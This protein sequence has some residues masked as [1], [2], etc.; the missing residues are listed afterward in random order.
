[1]TL[2]RRKDGTYEADVR[3][4]AAGRLHVSLRTAS[5]R[6]A[7]VAHDA[8]QAL[9]R[10]GPAS[11]VAAL[12]ARTV[13]LAAV[14]ECYAAGQPFASLAPSAETVAPWPTLADACADYLAALHENERVSDETTRHA[15]YALATITEQFGAET[16]VDA[17]GYREAEAWARQR[18]RGGTVSPMHAA[19]AVV[20]FRA[21]YAWLAARE[22]KAARRE[23][24]P[25]RPL[26]CPIDAD[27]LPMKPPA[28]TAFLTK[29]EIARLLDATPPSLLAMVGLALFAGLRAGEIQA[30]RLEDV[31]GD[32]VKIASKPH[33]VPGRKPWRTKSGKPRHV[34][35]GPWL[36][37]VLAQHARGRTTGWLY[38]AGRTAAAPRDTEWFRQQVRLIV[39]RAQLPYGLGRQDGVTLHTLRHTFA[40]QHVMAGTDLFTLSE[41]LGHADLRLLRSTY[42][43][44][45]PDHR[46]QTAARLEAAIAPEKLPATHTETDQ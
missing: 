42:G 1:V 22:A 45:S 34:T 23:K 15:R 12:R 33:W 7:T 20:R 30:L 28:R 9:A 46:A 17:I 14:V 43:H 24:R 4:P 16:R 25:A 39:E 32:V 35:I 29:P 40:A 26:E 44:L 11:V 8:V 6:Q 21:L 18:I 31:T 2:L 41:L 36:A 27:V 38:P 37:Q 5:K 13:T 3:G 19:Q 10:T